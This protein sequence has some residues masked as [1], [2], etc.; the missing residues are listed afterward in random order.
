ML[1]WLGRPGRLPSKGSGGPLSSRWL[2]GTLPSQSPGGALQSRKSG[3]C[4]RPPWSELPLHRAGGLCPEFLRPRGPGQGAAGASS[5]PRG[6]KGS[7]R[8]YHSRLGATFLGSKCSGG[9]FSTTGRPAASVG[10]DRTSSV[11]PCDRTD[12]FRRLMRHHRHQSGLVSMDLY[13][14]RQHLTA[15]ASIC[16]PSW[17]PETKEAMKRRTHT[18]ESLILS[19]RFCSG[20][21][22]KQRK[23]I[24]AGFYKS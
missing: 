17:K 6:Q 20:H 10:K 8:V 13:R 4:G 7:C 14:K 16:Q 21:R 5:H 22:H 18:H 12:I 3:G 2:G 23:T 24:P 1:C 15:T 9:R 19:K 11:L